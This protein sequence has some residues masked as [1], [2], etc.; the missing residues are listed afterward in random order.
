MAARTVNKRLLAADEDSRA[1]ETAAAAEDDH[2]PNM[3]TQL[4]DTLKGLL[5]A[6][7]QEQKSSLSGMLQTELSRVESKKRRGGGGGGRVA[8]PATTTVAKVK[9]SKR[10]EEDDATSATKAATLAQASKTTEGVTEDSYTEAE[11]QY[12]D[13]RPA[14]DPHLQRD[15]TGMFRTSFIYDRATRIFVQ[16][17]MEKYCDESYYRPVVKMWM[18]GKHEL[19]RGKPVPNANTLHNWRRARLKAKAPVKIP[20]LAR[21]VLLEGAQVSL[22]L[23]QER[24]GATL[25]VRTL[26]QTFMKML[27]LSMNVGNLFIHLRDSDTSLDKHYFNLIVTSKSVN[28]IVCRAHFGEAFMVAARL[29]ADYRMLIAEYQFSQRLANPAEQAEPDPYQSQRQIPVLFPNSSDR[30]RQE[31]K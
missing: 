26:Y 23:Q 15:T 2:R 12:S 7:S 30:Q 17:W 25:E 10:R 6:L 14:F 16:D 27:E 18:S 3:M 24:K 11:H 28:V 22:N 19:T 9:A 5:G 31:L 20:V 1:A 4:V 21:K 13:Q 29:A 8:S